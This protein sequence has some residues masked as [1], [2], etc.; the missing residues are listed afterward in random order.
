MA[1][2]I[3]VRRAIE[4]GASARRAVKSRIAASE[5]SRV[6]SIEE[7]LDVGVGPFEVGDGDAAVVAAQDG[8]D[9]HGVGEGLDV[10]LALQAGLVGVDASGDVDGQHQHHV[11]FLAVLRARRKGE[12]QECEQGDATAWPWPTSAADQP[13]S[14]RHKPYRPSEASV[15]RALDGRCRPPL[16]SVE[17]P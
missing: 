4:I 12:E 16:A 17:R 5:S 14:I 7:L 9:D 2:L 10:A 6:Q 15:S 13:T 11:D 3:E 1:P 8:L